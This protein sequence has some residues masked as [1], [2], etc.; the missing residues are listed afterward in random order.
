MEDVKIPDTG[1]GLGT[2]LVAELKIPEHPFDAREIQLDLPAHD[3]KHAEVPVAMPVPQA[4]DEPTNAALRKQYPQML[5]TVDRL[6]SGGKTRQEAWLLAGALLA[7]TGNAAINADILKAT[8][9]AKSKAR[10][11]GAFP[12]AIGKINDVL[13]GAAAPELDKYKALAQLLKG[14]SVLP[15]FR[16]GRFQDPT[17]MMNAYPTIDTDYA[18]GNVVI[19]ADVGS[20][21]RSGADPGYYKRQ[22]RLH[23]TGG[24]KDISALNPAQQE[25]VYAP[26]TAYLVTNVRIGKKKVKKGDQSHIHIY[27]R[28]IT[29]TDPAWPTSPAKIKDLRTAAFR[30]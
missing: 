15:D 22:Y 20:V 24:L 3:A 28:H 2:G 12:K 23:F 4:F 13:R 16:P 9:L 25:V 1:Y 26:G 19:M 5:T 27:L 6:M 14:I 7:Y 30:G 8:G 10:P 18:V 17:R 11:E 29:N 21:N